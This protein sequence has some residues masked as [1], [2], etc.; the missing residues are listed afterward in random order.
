MQTSDTR[1]QVTSIGRDEWKLAVRLHG[2]WQFTSALYRS[3]NAA[4]ADVGATVTEYLRHASEVATG[5][6][7]CRSATHDHSAQLP[8]AQVA[9]GL[10]TV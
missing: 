3:K 4:L 6:A 10:A 5:E 7:V 8:D 1:V 2:D 9:E